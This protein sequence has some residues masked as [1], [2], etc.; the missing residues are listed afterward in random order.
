[1]PGESPLI[2][3]PTARLLDLE[4]Q[5]L[6]RSKGLIVT[7]VLEIQRTPGSLALDFDWV[8]AAPAPGKAVNDTAL[9]VVPS[10]HRALYLGSE[11]ELTPRALI[12]P[13]TP[14]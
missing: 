6:L 1:M 12:I 5:E 10:Q 2:L 7:S 13:G 9:E 11:L 4:T 14:Y 8:P 3:T